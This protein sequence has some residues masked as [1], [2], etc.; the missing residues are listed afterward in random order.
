V[1]PVQLFSIRDKGHTSENG[2]ER[3][4]QQ[5]AKCL[6]LNSSSGTIFTGVTSNRRIRTFVIGAPFSFVTS[7]KIIHRGHA[8]KNGTQRGIP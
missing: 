5:R 3:G 6:G 2:T 1:Y 8:S 7:T 4:T